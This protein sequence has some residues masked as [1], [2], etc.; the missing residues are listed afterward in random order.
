MY[1]KVERQREKAPNNQKNLLPESVQNCWLTSQC[2]CHS[3]SHSSASS[4]EGSILLCHSHSSWSGKE[5]WSNISCNASGFHSLLS[6]SPSTH[7]PGSKSCAPLP[8][9]IISS[10]QWS[11]WDCWPRWRPLL[12]NHLRN[13]ILKTKCWKYS[14]S[15]GLLCRSDRW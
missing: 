12:K 4:L 5:I 8:G 6:W 14:M 1:L 3:A 15:W 10:W 2:L 11:F 7:S 13:M 9:Y